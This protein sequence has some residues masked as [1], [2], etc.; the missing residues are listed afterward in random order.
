[1][2]VN[3]PEY[4]SAHASWSRAVTTALVAIF[5]TS[6]IPL[7]MSSTIT[8]TTRIYRSLTEPA[9]EVTDARIWAGLHLRKSMSD[10]ARLGRHIA[11]LV[12]TCACGR[13]SLT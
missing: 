3:H 8:G 5:G 12:A 2:T 9:R 6:R 1:L 4:P 10:G 7:T 13:P 11:D